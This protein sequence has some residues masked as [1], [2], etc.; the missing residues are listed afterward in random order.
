MLATASTRQKLKSY[1]GLIF[2]VSWLIAEAIWRC[3]LRRIL[4]LSLDSVG[5]VPWLICD[6]CRG[7]Q[8]RRRSLFLPSFLCICIYC[9]SCGS[10][11][12]HLGSCWPYHADLPLQCLGLVAPG[13][14]LMSP[15][16]NHQGSPSSHSYHPWSRWSLVRKSQ[17]K[18]SRGSCK[19]P[20]SS[21]G[22][23]A[24]RNATACSS[25]VLCPSYK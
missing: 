3:G 15:A 21:V 9:F 11:Y 4:R 2:L 18:W 10:S 22:P 7:Y 20:R 24:T 17:A 5:K 23:W 25:L 14:E 13:I 8:R 12:L 19:Y 6:V 1:T 16:L